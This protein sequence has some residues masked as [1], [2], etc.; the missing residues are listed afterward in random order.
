MI[1][2]HVQDDKSQPSTPVLERSNLERSRR[3]MD[4]LQC[5]DISIDYP[6]HISESWLVRHARRARLLR[7]T[8]WVSQVLSVWSQWSQYLCCI[9]QRARPPRARHLL[10]STALW[11][12][13]AC[14]WEAERPCLPL[15]EMQVA[16][17]LPL[18]KWHFSLLCFWIFS[19]SRFHLSTS[20]S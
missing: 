15:Q 14:D 6:S 19:H 13:R 16:I 1:N 9:L 2:M 10:G 8:L 11:A 7:H 4:M 18:Q 12:L 17:P 5:A 3:F 20:R